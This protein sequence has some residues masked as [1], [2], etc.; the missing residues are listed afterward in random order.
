MKLFYSIAVLI[1]LAIG[2]TSCKKDDANIFTPPADP[3]SG[4]TKIA[5]GNAV[6]AGMKVQLWSKTALFTGY[7]FMFVA[8][9]DSAKG[10]LVTDAHVHLN[11]MMNMGTMSHSAPFENPASTKAVND[12][13][14][15]QIVFVMS[16]MGGTWTVDMEVHNHTTGIEGSVSLPV[17]VVDVTPPV[18]KSF[19]AKNDST[20]LYLSYLLPNNPKV[21]INDFEITIHKKNAMM[22]FNPDSSYTVALVPE[23]PSMGHGSPNNVNP[24]HVGNGHYKGKVNFTMTGAWR[25]NLDIYKNGAVVDTT[26]YFDVTLP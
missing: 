9:I 19:T 25:L 23:M 6:G 4:L 18:M 15:C 2:I 12:L 17:T 3:F 24:V 21:G 5:E 11:P 14:P 7:N 8:V 10:T 1:F 13:F 26:Q 22:G 20:K 16:S